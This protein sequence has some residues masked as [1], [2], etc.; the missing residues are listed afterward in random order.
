MMAQRGKFI[1]VEGLEG[2]GKSTIINFIR[3]NLADKVPEL[4]C[5]REPGGTNVGE[6]VRELVK[7]TSQETLD[8]RAELLLFYAARVQ[9]IENVIKPALEQGKWVLGDRFELSSFAYQGGGRG[10]DYNL[11]QHLSSFCL[12]DFKPDLVLFLDISPEIGLKRAMGRGKFDRIEQ[13]PIAFFRNV[14]RKYHELLKKMDNVVI[15]NAEQRI[16]QVQL[17]VRHILEKLTTYAS[18]N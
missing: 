18:A 13:E 16:T 7:Q 14:Y 5:T 2:A 9:L 11:I 8:A 12:E 10:L 4:I 6:V 17:E 1:V 15:I 3:K